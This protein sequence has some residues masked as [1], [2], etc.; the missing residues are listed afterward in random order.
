MAPG[1]TEKPLRKDEPSSLSLL[2]RQFPGVTL[3]YAD[4]LGD[5]APVAFLYRFSAARVFS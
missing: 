4:I 2:V 1:S 5:A 3:D